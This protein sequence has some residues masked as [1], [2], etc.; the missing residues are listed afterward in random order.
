LNNY[1][2]ESSFYPFFFPL[3]HLVLCNYA[4]D[5]LVGAFNYPFSFCLFNFYVVTDLVVS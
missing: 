2:E 1:F 4:L 3:F 5:R